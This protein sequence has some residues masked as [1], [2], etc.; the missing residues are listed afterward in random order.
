MR[1]IVLEGAEALLRLLYPMLCMHCQKELLIRGPL[2]CSTCLEQLSLVEGKGRCRTCFH[3]LHKGRCEK[4]IHRKVVVHHQL[5]ACE[6]MGPAHTLLAEIDK[7][8]KKAVAAA[9]SLMAYQWLEAKFL[10]PEILIPLPTSFWKQQ[11]VGFD[12]HKQ[13]AQ[14]LGKIF[15]V[16]TLSVLKN[17]FDRSRF[18]TQ[19][20]FAYRLE[21]C[22]KKGENLCDRRVLLITLEQNDALFRQVGKALQ[23]FFPSQIDALAFVAADS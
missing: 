11:K 14:E 2:F 8:H 13:L 22:K 21:G 5:A 12:P 10:L 1:R 4:C 6:R 18:L 3:E 20:E 7:G 23:L 17:K 16:P 9:A 15:N 19:G